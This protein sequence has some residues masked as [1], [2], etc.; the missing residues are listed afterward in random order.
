MKSGYFCHC[1]CLGIKHFHHV[2]CQ[3]CWKCSGCSVR[4]RKLQ[5]IPLYLYLS[6]AA[7]SIGCYSAGA[8]MAVTKLSR[9]QPDFLCASSGCSSSSRREHREA[10]KMC[11]HGCAPQHASVC[12]AAV[13]NYVVV[14][15]AAPPR[16][17]VTWKGYFDRGGSVQKA[18][19]ISDFHPHCGIE[20]VCISPKDEGWYLNHS[21]WPM[22]QHPDVERTSPFGGGHYGFQA[23]KA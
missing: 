3:I 23:T 9:W 11:L 13:S 17:C 4:S 6:S 5:Q 8:K 16:C 14:C 15:L 2:L 1:W 7:F 22:Q 12:A 20:T 19:L 18:F 21:F 10:A